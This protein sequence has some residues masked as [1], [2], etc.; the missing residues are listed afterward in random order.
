MRSSGSANHLTEERLGGLNHGRRSRHFHKNIPILVIPQ[1]GTE[2]GI[3]LKRRGR[4]ARH[5]ALKSP[6]RLNMN[7]S[8][9]I[10][11]LLTLAGVGISKLG[12]P[13]ID[14][15]L[16]TSA[17]PRP[18]V[19]KSH[20]RRAPIRARHRKLGLAHHRRRNNPFPTRRPIKVEIPNLKFR[21]FNRKNRGRN[22]HDAEQ[23]EK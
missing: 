16:N 19:K 23:T 20:I 10:H 5:P 4:T 1:N 17:L 18:K 11:F 15:R 12:K 3:I 6:P 14:I 2:Q 13:A 22:R 7:D 21:R 8:R 9:G